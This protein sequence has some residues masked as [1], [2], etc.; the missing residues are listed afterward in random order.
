MPLHRARNRIQQHD[1]AVKLN[2]PA[3]Q[4]HQHLLRV[5]K[6]H[7][8]APLPAVAPRYLV[9]TDN[10]RLGETSGQRPRLTLG[11]AQCRLRG[12]L[13]QHRR[14]VKIGGCRLKGDAEPFHLFA[15]ENR[16]RT[17]NQRQLQT[18][19]ILL[20]VENTPEGAV[21][22]EHKPKLGHP[23]RHTVTFFLKI[24]TLEHLNYIIPRLC[25][26]LI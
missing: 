10:Q 4:M 19:P 24:L 16:T 12:R 5:G 2:L 1:R 18:H 25:Q 6:V 8:L 11:K 21:K 23:L 3:A 14:F 26:T 9:R 13:P 22:S 20:T 7:R 17:Q 15:A